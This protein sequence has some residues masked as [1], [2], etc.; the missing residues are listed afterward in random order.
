MSDYLG[1]LNI[2]TALLWLYLIMRIVLRLSS[3]YHAE[4][5]RFVFVFIWLGLV[6]IYI[7][8]LVYGSLNPPIFYDSFYREWVNLSIP[9][10][11][12]TMFF[13]FM[14]IMLV[15]V[16]WEVHKFKSNNIAD[17]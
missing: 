6:L 7:A 14:F 12:M 1:P 3:G 5:S 17:S 16:S 13:V 4:S 15:D 10:P 8:A 9:L 2:L 11:M